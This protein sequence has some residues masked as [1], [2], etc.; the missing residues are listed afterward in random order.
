M[1]EFLKDKDFL[2]TLVGIVVL[3]MVLILIWYFFFQEGLY[4]FYLDQMAMKH[5]DPTYFHYKGRRRDI[6]GM[7]KRDYYL[8][9]DMLAKSDAEPYYHNDNK[10]QFANTTDYLQLNP[11]YR[12]RPAIKSV[13]LDHPQ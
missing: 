12:P 13:V 9:H 2:Y 11:T 1:F 5:E 4:P 7:S 3:I 8:E 10:S 6:L